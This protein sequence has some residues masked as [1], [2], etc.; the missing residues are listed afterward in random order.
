MIRIKNLSNLDGWRITPSRSSVRFGVL[1]DSRH[2][3]N[4]ARAMPASGWVIDS[5]TCGIGA[6][7]RDVHQEESHP[8]LILLQGAIGH[9]NT[10]IQPLGGHL[11]SYR[12]GS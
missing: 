3:G 9:Q 2:D 1:G 7:V 5:S 4:I 11:Q 10:V 6:K 8:K 12:S